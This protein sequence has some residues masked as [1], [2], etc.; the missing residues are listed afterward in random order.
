M[1]KVV[2]INSSPQMNEGHTAIILNL[3]VDGMR[4]AGA[5]VELLFTKKLKILPCTGEFKCWGETPGKCYIRDDMDVV[6]PKL[7]DADTW[8]LGI[9]LYVPM[10]GE[11]QNLLNRTMPLLESSVDVRGRRMFPA[12][13]KEFK[14]RRI[15]LVSSCA[16]W[17]MENFDKLVF[18]IKEI[19]E[20]LGAEYAGSVLRPHAV[21]LK[22]MMNSGQNV[23]S[24]LRAAKEAGTELVSKGKISKE[25]LDKVSSPLITFEEYLE[26][27]V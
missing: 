25:T 15:V 12:R 26:N 16:F 17:E 5:D 1:V 10:P 7:R 19:A 22:S 8:V 14:L 20:A 21:V 6:L 9:P 18:T 11:M 24:I 23:D 13:R 27:Y 3:F 2:A 4:E